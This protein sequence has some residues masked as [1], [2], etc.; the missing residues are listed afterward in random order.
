MKKQKIVAVSGVKNSGKTTLLEKLIPALAARGVKCA[1]IKHDGHRF[2]PDREGTDSFRMLAAG[3]MGTAVFDGEKFQAVKFAAVTEKDLIA[4]YPE[5]DLI[6]LE[7]FKSSPWPK[8]EILRGDIS[9]ESVC[10][11][12]TLLALVTDTPLRPPGIRTFGLEDVEA[13][14]DLLFGYIKE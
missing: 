5:A 4:L 6:L 11:P 9:A 13:L 1:V 10:D 14:A 12:D 2:A 3:A 7:G 8:I